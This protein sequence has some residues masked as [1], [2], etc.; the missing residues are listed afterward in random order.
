MAAAA[1][2]YSPDV[3]AALKPDLLEILP[4]ARVTEARAKALAEKGII[5]V[6]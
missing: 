1:L 5:T 6:E 3:E 2:R 4:G